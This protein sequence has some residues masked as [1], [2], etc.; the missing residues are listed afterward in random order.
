M[1]AFDPGQSVVWPSDAT[2]CWFVR[3]LDGILCCFVWPPYTRVWIL[4][5]SDSLRGAAV[6]LQDGPQAL[7]GHRAPVDQQVRGRAVFWQWIVI[8]VLQSGSSGGILCIRGRVHVRAS[9]CDGP[10]PQNER[11]CGTVL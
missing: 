11:G 7:R 5:L 1:R 8:R 3:P 9:T 10:G 6:Q 2:L 4:R